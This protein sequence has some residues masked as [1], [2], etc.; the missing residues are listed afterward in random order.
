ME[1]SQRLDIFHPSF[2]IAVLLFSSVLHFGFVVRIAQLVWGLSYNSAFGKTA[3]CLSV[4]L[5]LSPRSGNTA[6]V[7]LL[8]QK[9]KK[10]VNLFYLFQKY[11]NPKKVDRAAQ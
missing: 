5:L 8:S 6:A 10:I 4:F 3:T 11:K 1:L 2:K 9:G 7:R